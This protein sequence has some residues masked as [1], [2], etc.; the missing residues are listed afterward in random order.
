MKIGIV[1]NGHVG[2]NVAELFKDREEVLTYDP[3]LTATNTKAEINTCDLA[4]ICVPTP[5]LEDGGCD[6]S[7]VEESVKWLETPL[8]IIKS[9]VVPGT[10]DKL[11]S[12]YS[13]RLVFSPEYVGESKYH[14]SYWKDMLD[15]P[16]HIF[17]GDRKDTQP[18]VELYIKHCGPEKQY[19][20]TDAKSAELAKY[21]ENLFF[22]TKVTLVNEFY[23]ICQL[24]GVDWNDV[25]ELWLLDTRIN[26]M[27]TAVFKED[28]GFGG[29][30]YPKDL[31]ALVADCEKRGYIPELLS[32][33]QEVNKKFRAYNS[34]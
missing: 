10:T 24:Y 11:K 21:F 22:A 5:A 17:G 7:I 8:T 27:H 30:C 33:V 28:R 34:L 14:H 19:I 4:V 23:D 2:K 6:T 29:K 12:K 25:R 3:K 18:L 16:F 1:G 26:K 32:K 15:A 9:T 20:Q 31:F 13:K